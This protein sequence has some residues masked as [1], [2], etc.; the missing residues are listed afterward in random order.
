MTVA[1][2][3][4]KVVLDGIIQRLSAIEARVAAL[5]PGRP[6]S[7]SHGTGDQ[8]RKAGRRDE[9]EEIAAYAD[10]LRRRDK[11]WKE[12]FQ[13]CKRRWPGNEHVQKVEQIRGIWRRHYRRGKKAD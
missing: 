3:N 6:T 9:T 12:V 10:Q 4:T 2:D 8:G 7:S 11:S 1:N 13:H 5:P